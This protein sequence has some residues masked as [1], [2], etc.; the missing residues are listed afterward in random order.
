MRFA[1]IRPTGTFSRSRERRTAVEVLTESFGP[2]DGGDGLPGVP[3]FGATGVVPRTIRTE[4]RKRGI[5]WAA[6][7]MNLDPAQLLV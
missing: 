7:E 3:A 5:V 6:G 1:L 4:W 2:G